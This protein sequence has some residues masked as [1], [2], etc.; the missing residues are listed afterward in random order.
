MPKSTKNFAHALDDL[1]QERRQII[2]AFLETSPLIVGSITQTKGRCGKPN[3][4]CAEQPTHDITLLMTTEDN[5]RTSQ[6]IRKD[7][8]EEVLAHWQRYK[9]LKKSITTLK[10]LNQ[11]EIKM[12]L[13]LI[14][15]RKRTYE[16]L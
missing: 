7:D 11:K 8:V 15:E 1:E 4:A 14:Q 9:V 16:R 5:H 3:C 13:Q 12:L 2:A 6:L 10:E